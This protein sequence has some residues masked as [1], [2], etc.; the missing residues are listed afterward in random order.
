MEN[1]NN[2]NKELLP[3]LKNGTRIKIGLTENHIIFFNNL[4]NFLT[5]NKLLEL[6]RI[7][8]CKVTP[9]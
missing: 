4:M 3:A 6:K 9:N 2:F 5:P 7:G 1:L 8:N